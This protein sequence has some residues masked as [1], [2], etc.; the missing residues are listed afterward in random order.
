M[1]KTP[2]EIRLDLLAMAQG[3]LSDQNI[4]KRI[5]AENDWNMKCE[6]ARTIGE[7]THEAPTFPFFPDVSQ[8]DDDAVIAMAKKL[9]DFVSNG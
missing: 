9:N 2:Y 1:S 8:Y 6:R 3:I 7:I 5:K 4:N